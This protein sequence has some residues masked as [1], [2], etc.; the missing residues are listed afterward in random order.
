MVKEI[1]TSEKVQKKGSSL[2]ILLRKQIC[3][4]LNIKEDDMVEIKI[5]KVKNNNNEKK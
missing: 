2:Y 1:T 5:K 4:E 3:K